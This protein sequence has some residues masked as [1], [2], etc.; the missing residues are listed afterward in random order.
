MP[1]LNKEGKG[2]LYA[3]VRAKLPDKLD[4]RQ[5]ELFDELKAAG[6]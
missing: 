1:R 5:R 6:V 4:D 3:K 2:D